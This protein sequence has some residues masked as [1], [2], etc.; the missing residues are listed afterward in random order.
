MKRGG[1]KKRPRNERCFS[2]VIG[3]LKDQQ[4]LKTQSQ[5]PSE[6]GISETDQDASES[7]GDD[8]V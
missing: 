5:G 4:T 6:D 3:R 7:E 8:I 1:W 2:V